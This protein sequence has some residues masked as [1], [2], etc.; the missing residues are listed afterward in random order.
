[1][2]ALRKIEWTAGFLEGEGSFLESGARILAAQ[3]QREPLERLQKYFGGGICLRTKQKGTHSPC[4]LWH[5]AGSKAVGLSMTIHSLMSPR[6]KG[7]IERMLKTW[8]SKPR[9][10]RDYSKLLRDSN[11]RISKQL[12]NEQAA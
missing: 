12:P 1:M 5:L 7:Q 3:V 6:R 2:R 9:R 11:G 4:F 8:R 10:N